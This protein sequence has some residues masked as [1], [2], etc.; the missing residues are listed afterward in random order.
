MAKRTLARSSPTRFKV[1]SLPFKALIHFLVVCVPGVTSWS[2][3]VVCHVAVQAS[4]H[5]FL[6]RL[7]FLHCLLLAPWSKMGCPCTFELGSGL[8]ILLR[9][10][11]C[12]F[13]GP[14]CAVL[15]PSAS[16]YMLKSESVIRPALFVFPRIPL[17]IQGLLLPPRNFTILSSISVAHIAATLGLHGIQ[18]FL[19]LLWTLPVY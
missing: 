1:S 14:D 4:Q 13:L 6:Y 5:S 10:S 19:S 18:R 11:V 16:S 3:L 12:L 17:P 8:S 15:V 2:T 7:S 9:G